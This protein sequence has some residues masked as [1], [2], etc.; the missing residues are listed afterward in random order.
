MALIPPALREDKIE[1]NIKQI[2]REEQ[3]SKIDNGRERE[4]RISQ[5]RDPCSLHWKNSTEAT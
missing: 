3:E 2:K 4:W 1:G 5:G